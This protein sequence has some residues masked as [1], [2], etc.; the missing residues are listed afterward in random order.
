MKKIRLLLLIVQAII[1]FVLLAS[2]AQTTTSPATGLT[3]TP[4]VVPAAA[5]ACTSF[6]LDNGNHCVFGMNQDNRIDAGLLFVNKR[7]VLKTAWDPSTSGEYARWTSKYGSVTIVHGGYQMAW[8][9]MNEAGLM[10]STMALGETQ[11]PAPDERPPIGSSF[12]AQYQL[13]NHI[14]VQ[15]VITSDAQV[16]IADTVDHYLV[17]DS[18]GDCATIE[19]LEGKMV[20]HSGEALPVKALANSSYQE[21]VRTWE[22][23]TFGSGVMVMVHSV[24]PGSPA[25]KAGLKARDWI[26]AVD[27]VKL[28]GDR[29]VD[30]LLSE[31]LSAHEVGDAMEF[32]IRRPGDDGSVTVPVELG[33]RIT[34]E[35]TE[36][37]SLAGLALS[38]SDSS[39]RFAI[40][41]DR[42]QAFEPTEA[43]Q[44]VG[45][46]FATLEAVASDNTA[47]SI[48]FDPVN[49]QVHF[50]TNKNPQ[51]RYVDF[52]RLDF[53]CRTPVRMLDIHEDLS[54]DISGDLVRYSHQ[55]SLNHTINF[56]ERYERVDTHPLVIEAL[57]RGLESF[58]CTEV[59]DAALYPD[60][61][62]LSPPPIAVWPGL[63]VLHRLLPVWL[64]LTLGA[65]AFLLWDLAR[66]T[67]APWGLR[68]MWGLVVV[69]FGPLGLLA[70]V[71]TYRQPQR[72]AA[73]QAAMTKRRCALGS[74]VC[75]VAAYTAALILAHVLFKALPS[76]GS[77]PLGF[78]TLYG[79]LFIFGLL[80]VRAPLVVSV[81]GGGYWDAVRRTLPA[82]VFSVNTT[83]VGMGPALI[84][85]MTLLGSFPIH[86]PA[87][88]GN[89]IF[90]GV[91]ALTALVG[92][93]V[94]YPAQAW[95][96]RRGFNLWPTGW[97]ADGKAAREERVVAPPSLRNARGALTSS[98]VLLVVSVGLTVVS[99]SWS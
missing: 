81:L 56:I 12:W 77:R 44:A 70:Y 66:G 25:A 85:Q 82:E 97:S 4:S 52:S 69:L 30:A 31:L 90:W 19:F 75:S 50:R 32:T 72:S 51:I 91:L 78:A 16:R 59:A 8:A 58:P 64:V 60:D 41:V 95:M 45:Y 1:L 61:S 86:D 22:E 37:P 68:L 10:I 13:D 20:V 3:D 5:Q 21:S 83:L 57:L 39:R 80:L 40:V 49:L 43:A 2:C 67:R 96:A 28:D 7:N 24:E 89:L 15:E 71:L 62:G 84:L 26:V 65:L 55:V 34:E 74:A 17:C 36:V 88:P 63:L 38:V 35:G 18:K 6:C 76:L 33:S 92:I 93:L 29:R 94:S 46:A 87:N 73:P 42:L 9:G 98:F 14:T 47:W 11:N 48:V 54:G 99:L 53:S 23:G 79:L 27:G